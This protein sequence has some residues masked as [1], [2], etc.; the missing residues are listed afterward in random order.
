MDTENKFLS[1][2][3]KR[4]MK[5][6][7]MSLKSNATADAIMAF[8]AD[9][10]C[11]INCRTKIEDGRMRHN[12][13]TLNGNAGGCTPLML[14]AQFGRVDVV[15]ALLRG[16]PSPKTKEKHTGR[17]ALHIA[18]MVG[19]Q[20]VAEELITHGTDI[21]CQ[22]DGGFTPL[23]SAANQ[24]HLACLELLIAHG[25]NVNVKDDIGCTALLIAC[26]SGSHTCVEVL[27]SYG[28]DLHTRAKS[29]YTPLHRAVMQGAVSCAEKLVAEGADTNALDNDG[30]TPYNQIKKQ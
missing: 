21:D 8:V 25:A 23:H 9:P 28:A 10:R 27:A 7:W 13:V 1:E 26:W 12:N 24:G 5:T 4:P 15:Q 20:A 16:G 19:S 17:T 3:P 2:N 30:L 6:L 29:G 11:G 18:A 22:H 14:A